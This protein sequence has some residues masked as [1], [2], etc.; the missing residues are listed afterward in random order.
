MFCSSFDGSLAA[1]RIPATVESAPG[2]WVL[3]EATLGPGSSALL[4]RTLVRRNA[5]V[6]RGRGVGG[7]G[8]MRG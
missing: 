6:R 8:E 7:G 2:A 3:R 5:R 1:R 4:A